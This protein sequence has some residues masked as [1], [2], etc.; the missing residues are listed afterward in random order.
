LGH[1]IFF[2]IQLCFKHSDLKGSV[3]MASIQKQESKVKIRHIMAD[4]TERD[5]VT[6]LV[7]SYEACPEVYHILH[8]MSLERARKKQWQKQ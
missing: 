5:S 3:F 7:V 6:G 8:Q 2:A 1:L 4:G